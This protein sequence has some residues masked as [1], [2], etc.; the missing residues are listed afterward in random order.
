MTK[1]QRLKISLSHS[2]PWLGKKFSEEHKRKISEA[3]KGFKMSK[4]Q[5]KILSEL[6]KGSNHPN[7]KGGVKLENQRFRVTREYRNFLKKVLDRDKHFCKINNKDCKGII[8]VHHILN[9]MD[10]PEL[11]YNIN[12]GIT[13]CKNHHPRG[14]LNEKKLIPT[15][16]NLILNN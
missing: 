13:L 10:Y 9:C 14:R 8:E 3:R 16:K 2:K 1:E 11:R 7:W 5:R 4:E 12:N 6:K 15:F